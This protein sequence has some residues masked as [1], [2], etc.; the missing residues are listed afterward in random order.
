MHKQDIKN[1]NKTL[2]RKL[3][4]AAIAMFGF[5]FALVPLYNVMCDALG[6]NG[7]N[8]A[9]ESG[10]YQQNLKHKPADMQVDTSREIT[11]E[12]F[13]TLNQNMPW[14]F[15]AM[16]RKIKVHPGQTYTVKYYAKN[17]SNESVVAQAVPSLVPGL[18][19]KYFSKLE[20]F[21]FNNQ[22][23][24]PGEE[25]VMPLVFYVDPHLPKDV[26][27]LSMSYTFFDTEKR[28]AKNVEQG[29]QQNVHLVNK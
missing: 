19:W 14:E 11:V 2:T 16:T 25:K 5:G 3:F 24:A 13:S 18:A 21:C 8:R 7:R 12:F 1:S 15:R 10:E 28:S 29:A 26:Q 4:I 23:F 9:I 20:C 17:L 6:I 22:T 27:V